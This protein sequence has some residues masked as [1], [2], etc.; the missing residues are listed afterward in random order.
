MPRRRPRSWLAGRLRSA[1]RAADRF[2]GAL[3]TSPTPT[4]DPPLAGV[5]SDRRPGQP[6]EHWLQVVAAHAPGLLRDLTVDLPSAPAAPDWPDSGGPDGGEANGGGTDGGGTGGGGTGGGGPDRGRPGGRSGAG[7]HPGSRH[8]PR[9]PAGAAD[10]A[11]DRAGTPA[12]TSFALLQPTQHPLS[13]HRMPGDTWSEAAQRDGAGVPRPGSGTAGAAMPE[14]TSHRPTRLGGRPPQLATRGPAGEAETADAGDRLPPTGFGTVAPVDARSGPTN[15][16]A[17]SARSPARAH[18]SLAPQPR[19]ADPDT[20]KPR[21][22]A[23]GPG[24]PA[25]GASPHPG[26]GPHSAAGPRPD[27]SARLDAGQLRP[28]R[29][30]AHRPATTGSPQGNPVARHVGDHHLRAGDAAPGRGGG[31]G[32][33][34]PARGQLPP[35]DGLWPG[36][37]PTAGDGRWTRSGPP[38]RLPA[39][40]GRR[41]DDSPPTDDSRR[42]GTGR[43]SWPELETQTSHGGRGHPD[44][45]PPLPDD[46]ALWSP[47]D[48]GRPDAER[49]RR[50]DSEQAG[51]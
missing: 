42:A 46:R 12:A 9:S 34:F 44:P 20:T 23:A 24:L 16:S 8:T 19:P 21:S 15:T 32:S 1:A 35:G 17:R 37:G 39:R 41:P 49:L 40:D 30:S 7:D 45:W 27:G 26:A 25:T 28:A 3:D 36:S 47:P 38:A 11:E 4:P 6:P 31:S 2:A 10:P 50:L 5:G 29:E 14:Q 51:G 22:G 33:P 18:L 48:P 13:G 43:P